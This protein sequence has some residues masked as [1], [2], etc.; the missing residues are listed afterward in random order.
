MEHQ[1]R[2]WGARGFTIKSLYI[3]IQ[4]WLALLLLHLGTP[5]PG[6]SLASPDW[7]MSLDVRMSSFSVFLLLKLPGVRRLWA[8]AAYQVASSLHNTFHIS[9]GAD[10]CQG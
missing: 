7:P 1:P 2:D 9:S 8:A 5:H 10:K 3:G 4:T 6:V